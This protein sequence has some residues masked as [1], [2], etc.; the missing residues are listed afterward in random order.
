MS[1]VTI[2]ISELRSFDSD[3][4]KELEKLLKDKLKAE[5][6]VADREITVKPSEKGEMTSKDYLR[7]L[8]KKYL[9]KAEL[10]QDFRVIAGKDKTFI[11]KKRKG[12][13]ET[14]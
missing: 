3:E 2:D 5:F 13:G 12:A 6:E 11:I 14:G 1:S 9:H 10:K 7:V 4:I 8:L